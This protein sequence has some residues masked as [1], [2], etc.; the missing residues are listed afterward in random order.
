MAKSMS[1]FFMCGARPQQE[2]L[3]ALNSFLAHSAGQKASTGGVT[4]VYTNENDEKTGWR[5][6]TS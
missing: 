6:Q 3:K 1:L 4:N 2:N 5:V